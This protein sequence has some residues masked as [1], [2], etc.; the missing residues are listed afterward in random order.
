MPI[1]TPRTTRHNN[2]LPEPV[3]DASPSPCKHPSKPAPP[4]PG[5]ALVVAGVC[6]AVSGDGADWCGRAGPAHHGFYPHGGL[7]RGT[8]L[9]T[10]TRLADAPP[11]VWPHAGELAKRRFCEPP[12]QVERHHCHGGLCRYFVV[13]RAPGMGCLAGYWQHGVC[14]AV[15][16]VQ[17]RARCLTYHS[18]AALAKI[19]GRHQLARGMSSK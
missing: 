2:G 4:A 18:M 11:A 6:G 9:P 5:R 19:E 13:H 14:A 1:P 15:A 12:R 17:A 10:F 16:V 8:Q 7:G 3:R